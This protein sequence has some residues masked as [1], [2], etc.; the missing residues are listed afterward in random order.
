MAWRR[1]LLQIPRGRVGHAQPAAEFDRRDSLLGARHQMHR[2]EPVGQRQFGIGHNRARGH[3]PALVAA[4]AADPAPIDVALWIAAAWARH[5]GRLPRRCQRRQ[6]GTLG[7]EA[8]LERRIR[9]SLHHQPHVMLL[10][11]NGALDDQVDAQ[12]LL[13]PGLTIAGGIHDVVYVATESNTVYAIDA[14]S[15]AILISK[16]FGAPV[17]APLGCTNNGP[18]VGINGTPTI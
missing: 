4:G 8:L 13:V 1:R 3:R 14:S 10:A 18:N 2:A 6:A 16:N 5:A 17:P 9:Q 11:S 7:A 12:P 15:G